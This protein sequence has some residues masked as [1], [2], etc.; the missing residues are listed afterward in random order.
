MES[1]LLNLGCGEL[2]GSHWVNIDSSLNVFL[3]NHPWL[4]WVLQLLLP[5]SSKKAKF[6]NAKYL[7][8]RRTWKLDNNTFDAVYS[9]HFFEH[10]SLE[11]GTHVLKE[12]FRCL[13]PGGTIRFLMPAVD[14]DIR[15]IPAPSKGGGSARRD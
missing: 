4:K 5:A 8:L 15:R 7:D 13:K 11:D 12:A 9:S 14:K 2:V 3:D 10:L 6:K 1:K